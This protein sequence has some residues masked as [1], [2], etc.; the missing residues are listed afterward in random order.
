MMGKMI[1][2][3][4]NRPACPSAKD[5]QQALIHIGIRTGMKGKQII[6]LIHNSCVN[7]WILL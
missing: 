3:I 2:V 6:V 5:E 1:L 7:H 4:L